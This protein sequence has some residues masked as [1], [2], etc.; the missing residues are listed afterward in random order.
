M[1]HK[2]IKY[3]LTPIIV[4]SI[5]FSTATAQKSNRENAPYSRFGIGE[6]RNGANPLLKGMGSI[7]TAYSNPFAVNSYNPASYASLKLTLYEAGGIA[8]TRT[9]FSGSDKYPTGQAT[10]SNIN[11]GIPVSKNAGMALGLRPYSH[12]YYNLKDTSVQ[13]G[14]GNS[15]TTYLGDGTMHYAFIGA[16]GKYKGFSVGFNFGYLFGSI[17][18]STFIES[19]EDLNTV[20]VSNSE[21][22]Q[23]TR[24]GG[25]HWNAGIQHVANINDKLSLR[26]GATL[27]LSQKLKAS[28]QEYWIALSRV[29]AGSEDTAF[30]SKA[31]DGQYTLPMSYSVGVQLTSTDSW[32]LG[33][34]FTG[35]QSSQFRN[36]GNVD[37]V[38]GYSYRIALGGE[39]TPDP[40]ATRQ[41]LQRVTY[42]L[43]AYYGTDNVYLNNTQFDYYAV[44]FGASLPFKR[45]NDRLHTAFEIGKR[46]TESNGLFRENF[47]KFSLGIT[48]NDKWFIKR[49]YD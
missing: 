4:L 3:F 9:I 13:P 29:V 24:I 46:G 10:L 16:G 26:S 21:F 2:Y 23:H 7:T 15:V 34:D 30:A 17:N 18:K 49:R 12:V 28:R 44:T 36:Y 33:L 43:G 27:S 42:R 11:I 41:Y 32:T 37:S 6:Y 39:F 45:S 31:T 1:R 5:S 35:T 25:I 48:L 14:L 8:S 40:S 19:L 22:S 38:A 47:F 20:K